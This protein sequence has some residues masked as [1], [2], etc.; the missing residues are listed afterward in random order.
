MGNMFKKLLILVLAIFFAI[1]GAIS[2]NVYAEEQGN[3]TTEQASVTSIQYKNDSGEWVELTDSTEIK[4]GTEL[5]IKGSFDISNIRDSEETTREFVIDLDPHNIQLNNYDTATIDGGTYRIE[6]GKI[7]ITVTEEYIK[8]HG[9]ITGTFD[10]TG[11]VNVE[12]AS[13]TDKEKVEIKI[14]GKTVTIIYD[15]NIT[16]SSLS[17]NKEA[18]GNAYKGT[19]G[20]FYQDFKIT[21]YSY[22]GDNTVTSLTDKMGSKLSLSG[23]IT[24]RNDTTNTDIGTYSDFSSIN[25]LVVPNNNTVT[26][27]YT[28]KIDTDSSGILGDVLSVDTYGNSFKATYKTNKDN[29]KETDNKT[30]VVKRTDP[31]FSKTG[32]KDGETIVWTITINLGSYKDLSDKKFDGLISDLEDSL[33]KGMSSTT[34]L[35]KEDFKETTEGSG[36][37]TATYT[38]NI[39]ADYST[40]YTFKNTANFKFD[41]EDKEVKGEV[42][43][44]PTENMIEKTFVSY[45]NKE[46][47]WNIAVNFKS[48][49]TE[50]VLTDEPSYQMTK[51]KYVAIGDI[52]IIENDQVTTEGENIIDKSQWNSWSNVLAFK[53]SYVAE[54]AGQIKNITIKTYLSDN[55]TLTNG[56]TV[57]NKA[58]LKYKVNGVDGSDSSTATYTYNTKVLKSAS[59]DSNSDA[60]NYTVKIQLTANDNLTV[61]DVISVKDTVDQA[62]K[63][64][65]NSIGVSY[66]NASDNTSWIGNNIATPTV[67]YDSEKKTFSYVMTDDFLD[68]ITANPNKKYELHITYKAKPTDETNLYKDNQKQ[69]ITVT[70]TAEGFINGNSAG[71]SSTTTNY[72]AKDL[73]SKVGT[74]KNGNTTNTYGSFTVTINPNGAKINNGNP[75]K[76]VDQMNKNLVYDLTTIKVVNTA[77]NTELTSKEYKVVFDDEENSLTFTLPDATPLQITYNATIVLPSGTKL[78]ES[79]AGNDFTLYGIQE[80]AIEKKTYNLNGEY[81]P[82]VYIDGESAKLTILKYDSQ[83]NSIMLEGASFKIYT[84]SYDVNSLTWNISETESTFNNSNVFTT[85]D[86]GK[87]IVNGLLLDQ[88]YAI[89]EVKAPN[90]YAVAQDVFVVFKGKDF[91][92]LTLPEDGSVKVYNSKISTLNFADDELTAKGKLT[93]SKT[94]VAHEVSEADLQNITFTITGPEEYSCTLTLN[95]LVNEDGTY[96]KTLEDL[97]V[98][99]YTVVET[100]SNSNA[101]VTKTYKVNDVESETG[102]VIVTSKKDGNIEITNTYE[103]SPVAVGSLTLTKVI[104]GLTTEEDLSGISFEIK[105][106][107]NYS[108]TVSLAD[109]KQAGGTY[110]YTLNNLA[111]G[112]Y[113]VSENNAA[114]TGYNHTVSYKVNGNET[115]KVTVSE[116]ALSTMSITNTYTSLGALTLTKT[117][118]GHTVN[119]EDLEKISFIVTGPNDY[120]KTVKLNEFTLTEGKY[121]YSLSELTYG[122]YTVEESNENIPS[123]ENLTVTYVVN[124]IETTS[125][126]VSISKDTTSGTVAITNTYANKVGSLTLT[127]VI[128]GLTAEEDLSGISFEIKGPNNYSTT[129]SLA[130]MKQAGGTYSYTLNNLA[131]GEYTVSENNAAITGYNHTVSYKVNGNETPKVTVS[132]N[133]LSTMSITNTYTSLGALTLTKTFSGHTV[134]EEDLEKISFIVTGPNDYSKTVKLNEFTLTEGKYTYSLSELTYGTYTVEESN[135]NIPSDE[136]LTVTYVVNGIETTSHE[137]SISKDTTSGTVAITNTYANK[138]GSLTLTKVIEG[139]TAEEDLSNISFTI[140]GPNN[141]SKTVYLKD[142]DK[143]VSYTYRYTIDNLELG[144]YKIVENN[145]NINGYSVK[146]SFV[147]TNVYTVSTESNAIIDITNE[148]TKDKKEEKEENTPENKQDTYEYHIVTTSTH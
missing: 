53:D 3:T 45:A 56:T 134:N 76:A 32:V 94:F 129:V 112:E 148:Y 110:S 114:I 90:G 122:T 22:N 34:T 132:E 47:T 120:S 131:I 11:K 86:Q 130:D 18:V 24:V 27:T 13:T 124:G 68:V 82:N 37:Y 79:N 28:A 133:A 145:A 55:S 41:G 139:L 127:K 51:V 142:M 23:D 125:H 146:T 1:T 57:T 44:G 8:A 92:K 71:D 77:T 42:V 98:G 25:G 144:E 88:V 107:N 62:F 10:I 54:N 30:A 100:I 67:T 17:S 48:G 126:E 102:T 46:F 99:E 85:D 101:S 103:E 50:V 36:I 96:S 83:D 123:D 40:G 12:D 109:M 87:T 104:E 140:T 66:Y 81:S 65:E 78:D 33:G 70:N 6:N 5:R 75:L 72:T 136:N 91:D 93:L 16:E 95:D 43:V 9:N 74:F 113:T 7:Y 52:V 59:I 128:E 61:G 64:A 73:L 20:N 141:Y 29:E 63:I 111:I 39:T 89:K 143:V 84:A 31:S 119:E 116:N 35:T 58:T 138:V 105:G 135:E 97:T 15:K 69:T 26:L 118:S 60:I 19:D 14:D 2:T 147:S 106:P 137:V 80:N 108:T 117:F 49:M 21:L 4:N 121:T 115:P 38:T